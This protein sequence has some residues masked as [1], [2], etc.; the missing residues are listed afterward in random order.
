VTGSSN[1][2]NDRSSLLS[3]FQRLFGYKENLFISQDLMLQVKK[4][5]IRQRMR[6]KKAEPKRPAY[7][8]MPFLS[9]SPLSLFAVQTTPQQ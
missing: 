6:T 9:V 5:S 4:A 7:L 1:L 2:K 3:R 8:F